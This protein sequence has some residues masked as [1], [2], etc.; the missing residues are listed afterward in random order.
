[1]SRKQLIAKRNR[2]AVYVSDTEHENINRIVEKRQRRKR[3]LSTPQRDVEG[4][5]EEGRTVEKQ[6]R[7]LKQEDSGVVSLDM[8]R[9]KHT[10]GSRRA[11]FLPDEEHEQISREVQQKQR[12]ER[13]ALGDAGKS[14]S[15]PETETTPEI[16]KDGMER[17]T[18]RKMSN[19]DEERKEYENKMKR[20]F[21]DTGYEFEEAVDKQIIKTPESL[22]SRKNRA[23]I[24]LAEKNKKD[25]ETL[26]DK[27]NP[28]NS[29]TKDDVDFYKPFKNSSPD[30]SSPS[31]STDGPSMKSSCCSGSYQRNVARV[32]VSTEI[33]TQEKKTPLLGSTGRNKSRSFVMEG[34]LKQN[35][36]KQKISTL[37]LILICFF[38]IAIVIVLVMIFIL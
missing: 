25:I 6:N 26:I 18:L 14:V 36:T 38:L 35:D 20:D 7:R 30:S 2:G 17:I 5:L 10:R 9:L 3:P 21:R 28:V 19:P 8:I 31:D 32:Q 16:A 27:F 1:M 29:P 4:N 33:T 37:V 24:Y 15:R 11:L 34:N 13:H 22:R 12:R 23:G